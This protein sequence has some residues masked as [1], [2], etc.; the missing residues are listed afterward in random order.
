MPGPDTLHNEG[1]TNKTTTQN[2]S[3]TISEYSHAAKDKISD[4]GAYVKQSALDIKDTL[5][6]ALCDTEEKLAN[7]RIKSKEPET[8]L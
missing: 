6:E 2:I 5:S 3:E 4:A 7:L 1:Q 8:V